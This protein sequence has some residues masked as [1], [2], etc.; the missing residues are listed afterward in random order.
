MEMSFEEFK[1]IYLR[2][3][4]NCIILAAEDEKRNISL[5]Q[6]EKDIEQGDLIR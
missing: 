1:K 3:E 5:I 6:P 2:E 4:S